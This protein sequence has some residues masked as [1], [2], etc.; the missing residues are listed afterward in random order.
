MT[1][2]VSDTH[3]SD[4]ELYAALTSAVAETWDLI[5]ASGLGDEGVKS[6]TFNTVGNQLNYAIGTVVPDGDFYRVSEVYVDEGNGQRRPISRIS[7]AEVQAFR[8]VQSASPIILYYIPCAPVW[9]T[10]SETFDGIN[11][12]E[13]HTLNTAAMYVMAKK[14]DDQAPF[15][16]RKSQLEARI[17]ASANRNAADPPRVV[18]KNMSR[19]QDAW[20]PYNQTVSAWNI[21]GSNLEFYYRYGYIR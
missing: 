3:L 9:S 1:D 8:P 4:A 7:P 16:R 13:E 6:V 20:L 21:R 19:R 14:N 12:W 17:K 10:G 15:Q 5:L 18:R 11:G 2:S